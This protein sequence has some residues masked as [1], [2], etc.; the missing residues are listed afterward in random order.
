MYVLVIAARRRTNDIK[1]VI[2]NTCNHI[3]Y[4]DLLAELTPVSIAA[5]SLRGSA[6]NTG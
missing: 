1:V 5:S 6:V 2:S 4:S 3:D